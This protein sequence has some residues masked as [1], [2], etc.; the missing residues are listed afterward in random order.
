MPIG[1]PWRPDRGWLRVAAYLVD[2]AAIAVAVRLDDAVDSLALRLLCGLVVI[3]V[4]LRIAARTLALVRLWRQQRRWT[5][6]LG[7]QSTVPLRVERPR[8][9]A[10]LVAIVRAAE[11]AGQK[12]RAVG[13]TLSFSDVAVPDDVVV[14]THRLRRVRRLAHLRPDVDH[15]GL[16]E[17]EAGA[18]VRDLNRALHRRGR[19]LENL[20]GYDGP[21]VAGALATGVHGT[22]LAF[23]PMA[24]T[25]ASIVIV[26]SGGVVHR[27]EPSGGITD[28]VAYRAAH[29]DHE[30]HQ[31]DDWFH[32][33]VVNLGSMGVVYAVT[34]RVVPAF[35]L[36]EKRTLVRWSTIR[37]GLTA[38]ALGHDR[39]ELFINPYPHHGGDHHC[40]R[41]QRLP[42]SHPARSWAE[43]FRNILSEL[44]THLPFSDRLLDA[45]FGAVPAAVPGL[46]DRILAGMQDKSYIDHGFRVMNVGAVNEYRVIAAEFAV[47]L[48]RAA[49]A[50]ETLFGVAARLRQRGLYYT[51]PVSLR[52]TGGTSHFLSMHEGG[53]RA[54]LEV[55]LFAGTADA[56]GLLRALGEALAP[57]GSRWHWGQYHELDSGPPLDQR[58]P[59]LEKWL[60]IYRQLN[61]Q[62]TFESPF[63]RRCGLH[64]KLTRED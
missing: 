41:T 32:A 13:A 62:G 49:D 5:N 63:T 57:L 45:A 12:V 51:C 58:F 4:G 50:V 17:I 28:A 26:A 3:G 33:A 8:D 30:L 22:G 39:V 46:L 20:G 34:L 1:D 14:E 40:I 61:R 7:N 25:V 31:D 18:R 27:I 59:R 44:V 64:S 19:A 11:A 42:T 29:P 2:V 38:A 10:R 16:V 53:P 43:R 48:E 36:E 56:I 52:F 54:T 60:A 35:R 47:P 24:D 37:D 9:L 6:R 21:T 23:G 55:A 15:R